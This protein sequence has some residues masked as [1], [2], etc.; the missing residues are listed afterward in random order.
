MPIYELSNDVINYTNIS[1]VDLEDYDDCIDVVRPFI[2]EKASHRYSHIWKAFYG[3]DSLKRPNC[4]YL[5]AGYIVI[6]ELA[7]GLLMPLIGHEVELLPMEVEGQPHYIVNII[8]VIDCLDKENSEIKYFKSNPTKIMRI[9]KHVFHE[10]HTMDSY[11]FKL[12]SFPDMF[13]TQKFK[14]LVEHNGLTGLRF[15]WL[16]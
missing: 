4:P 8:N 16:T 11:L 10:K 3:D 14:D 6:D 1:F 2:G 9:V 13:C 15:D 12:P 7:K 5:G